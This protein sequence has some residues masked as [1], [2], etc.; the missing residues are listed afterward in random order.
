MA[1]TK[2]NE[3]DW[4]LGEWQ[5]YGI[6]GKQYNLI[7]KT[8]AYEIGGVFLVERTLSMFPPGKPDTEFEMHQD[9]LVFHQNVEQLAAKGFYI[10]GFVS[11]ATVSVAEGGSQILIE[12][13]AIENGPPDTRTRYTLNRES[14]DAFTGQFEIAW[15]GQDFELSQKITLKRIG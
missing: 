13:T 3:L 7:R 12:S 15:P 9:F 8:Y 6:V 14:T 1:N 2:L 4:L 10:E 5:G 11:Q